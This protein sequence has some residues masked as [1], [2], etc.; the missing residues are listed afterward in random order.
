M[1]RVILP[2]TGPYTA[3]DQAK[4]DRATCFI[5]RG[6]P[7]S[8]TAKYAAAWGTRANKVIYTAGEVVFVSVE[9]A[10]RNRIPLSTVEMQRAVNASAWFITDTPL[11][12][13]RAY[14][15]G[16][17]EAEAFL[18]HAGYVETEPGLWKPT[19]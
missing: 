11:H 18:R 5:G 17:R 12:R 10:R 1:N 2:I 19:R 8:S 13:N 16:E 14:N 4:S 15:V 3:K 6:S 7:T 9:G